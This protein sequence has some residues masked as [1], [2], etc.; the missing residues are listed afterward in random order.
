M[1]QMWSWPSFSLSPSIS[2]RFHDIPEP[3]SNQ[4]QDIPE[5]MSNRF[6]DIPEPIRGKIVKAATNAMRESLEEVAKEI[7]ILSLDNNNSNAPEKLK[8]LTTEV[9]A[10]ERLGFDVKEYK[11]R[12][13]ELES[14]LDEWKEN[15]RI[16]RMGGG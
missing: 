8:H 2:N 14:T 1:D 6:Q 11:E 3:M 12:L 16:C 7:Q 5:P 15:M 9:E 10:A 13:A 4:F